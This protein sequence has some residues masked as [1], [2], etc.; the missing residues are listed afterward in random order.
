MS[1]GVVA[2]DHR[3]RA[4]PLGGGWGVQD[5]PVLGAYETNGALWLDCRCGVVAG[6]A[7]IGPSGALRRVPCVARLRAATRRA[8]E[9]RRARGGSSVPLMSVSGAGDVS[10]CERARRVAVTV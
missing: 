8:E 2:L 5:G 6:Q 10:K 9:G 3:R 1:G 7:C 4:D